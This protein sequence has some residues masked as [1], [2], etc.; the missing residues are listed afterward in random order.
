MRLTADLILSSPNFL[1]PIKERELDLRGN[2]ISV[3]EN[4]GATQDQFDCIDLS[5]NEITKLEGFP[6][7]NRLKTLFLN[8][9]RIN[10]IGDL[11]EAL[12]ELE[13]L[14][15]TNNRLNNLSDL[16]P[17]KQLKKL[18]RLSLLDNQVTKKQHYRLFVIHHLPK[19]KLLDF[20]KIK[21]KERQASEKL[22]GNPKQA[23]SIHEAEAKSQKQQKQR[24]S[25]NIQKA[26]SQATTLEQVNQLS[27]QLASGQVPESM[28]TT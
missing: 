18:Q 6:Q 20:R 22:F 5:D 21:P 10:R 12:P 19:L 23:Q 8:N 28:D 14:I 9:N 11:K 27:S 16:L 7:L 1:N 4:L 3:I 15:L 24:E 2:K 17:L 13:T 25:R 26:L